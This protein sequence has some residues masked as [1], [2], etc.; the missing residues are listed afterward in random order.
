MDLFSSSPSSFHFFV[1]MRKKNTGAV[2]HPGISCS[3]RSDRGN[4]PFIDCIKKNTEPMVTGHDGVEA[5]KIA[6][7]F[8]QSAKENKV[9]NL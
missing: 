5:L 6:E 7:K 1:W 8:R 4:E 2:Y 3:S 9:I